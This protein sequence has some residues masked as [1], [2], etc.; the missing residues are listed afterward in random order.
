MFEGYCIV[1]GRCDTTA[2]VVYFDAVKAII[3]E[4]YLCTA[5]QSTNMSI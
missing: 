4:A 2:V 3:L 5:G 1:I